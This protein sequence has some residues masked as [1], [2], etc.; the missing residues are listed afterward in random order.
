[1]I[2]RPRFDAR[3]P[4]EAGVSFIQSL[5]APLFRPATVLA[6]KVL[7]PSPSSS[8]CADPGAD[9]CWTASLQRGDGLIPFLVCIDL[10]AGQRFAM[11]F[12][13]FSRRTDVGPRLR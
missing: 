3:S 7:G 13:S 12:E 8:R 4:A 2:N 10:A 11:R 6:P 5:F 9:A 1:M